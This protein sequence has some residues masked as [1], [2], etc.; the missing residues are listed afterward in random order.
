MRT[1]FSWSG[2][3]MTCIAG[4]PPFSLPHMFPTFSLTPSPSCC[5]LRA[6]PAPW[7][8]VL[9]WPRVPPVASPASL[10]DAQ[11]SP[12]TTHWQWTQHRTL[13]TLLSY[14]LCPQKWVPKT[15]I[16]RK[17]VAREISWCQPQF[18][19]CDLWNIVTG[20]EWQCDSVVTCK[21]QMIP[22]YVLHNATVKHSPGS[23][24][25]SPR[26]RQHR[27]REDRMF[28]VVCVWVCEW[29]NVRACRLLASRCNRAN[30]CARAA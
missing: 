19:T 8:W 29:V 13:K 26:S 28:V 5:M 9:A 10:W 30:A 2:L 11:R 14:L 18:Q 20:R 3:S 12:S 21:Q 17:I 4:N 25:F 27:S 16:I 24:C 7:S 6:G 1:A 23:S 22:V 15:K